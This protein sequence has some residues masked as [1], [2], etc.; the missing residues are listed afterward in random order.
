MYVTQSIDM[1]ALLCLQDGP[2]NTVAL[3]AHLSELPPFQN[4]DERHLRETCHRATKR[5]RALGVV[6][7]VQCPG[8]AKPFE[9]TQSGKEDVEEILG[10]FGRFLG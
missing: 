6:T 7:E 4:W 10:S 1:L 3:M 8:A 9:L 2:L 5:L